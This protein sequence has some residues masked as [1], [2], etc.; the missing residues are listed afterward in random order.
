M[1]AW[2]LAAEPMAGPMAV[3]V[4]AASPQPGLLVWGRVGPRGMSLE[5]ALPVEVPPFMPAVEGPYRVR[6]LDAEGRELFGFRFQ[7]DEVEDG[8]EP[9][10]MDFAWVVPMGEELRDRLVRLELH[11][12]GGGPGGHVSPEGSPSS[13]PSQDSAVRLEPGVAL[14]WDPAVFPMAWVRNPASGQVVGMVESGR[15]DLSLWSHDVEVLFTDG[16]RG[17]IPGSDGRVRPGSW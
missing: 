17:W 3:G 1:L 15:V 2:R 8:P 14:E 16:I 12:P 5:P 10:E 6:G 9:G 11:G 7:P 4:E 13:D